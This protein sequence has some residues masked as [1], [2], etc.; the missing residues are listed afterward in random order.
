MEKTT[1]LARAAIVGE[2]VIVIDLIK[3]TGREVIVV[4]WPAEP[5]DFQS[6]ELASVTTSVV[7]VLAE[8]RVQLRLIRR[9]ER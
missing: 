3:D 8:A 5:T 1:D 4:T 7:A 6:R 9:A 2:H